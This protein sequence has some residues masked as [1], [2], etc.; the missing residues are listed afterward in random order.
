V[1]AYREKEGQDIQE[2]KKAFGL[3]VMRH[4]EIEDV[5]TKIKMKILELLSKKR[6]GKLIAEINITSQGGIGECFLQDPKEKV[7]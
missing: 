3:Q 6:Y 1:E 5:I 2:E 4:Q 7:K